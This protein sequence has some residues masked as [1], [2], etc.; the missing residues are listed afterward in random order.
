MREFQE[1]QKEL[2]SQQS[3]GIVTDHDAI[4]RNLQFIMDGDISKAAKVRLEGDAYMKLGT[5]T[6]YSIL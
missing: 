4:A 2:K 6:S 1:M 3:D 5:A